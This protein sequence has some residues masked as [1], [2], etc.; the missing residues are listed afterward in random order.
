M[1]LYLTKDSSM[2]R[3]KG[4]GTSMSAL[5]PP[6]RST[7]TWIRVSLVTRSSVAVRRGAGT[8]GLSLI[9]HHPSS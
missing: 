2:W 1:P 7:S 3:K 5:P 8:E 9:G 6:S 4:S